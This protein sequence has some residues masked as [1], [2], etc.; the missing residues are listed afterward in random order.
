MRDAKLMDVL[1]EAT[2]AALAPV[3][4]PCEQV[5]RFVPAIG[6]SLV[7]TERRLVLVREGADFRPRSGVQSWPLDRA[8]SVRATPIH[9]TT[10][11]IVIERAG[12]SAS[13]FVSAAQSKA[14]DAMIA[15]L[16]HR[17]YAED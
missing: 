2:R 13:V 17:I 5:T 9:H 7:L 12:R 4:D 15:E 14:A 3:L 11:R 1:P 6:C 10:G 8:L 16:R